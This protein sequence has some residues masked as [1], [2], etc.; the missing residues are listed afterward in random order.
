MSLI[1]SSLGNN[2]L[3]TRQLSR[4]ESQLEEEDSE[5][6]EECTPADDENNGKYQCGP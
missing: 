6:D 4:E 1:L 3:Y 5:S 2:E